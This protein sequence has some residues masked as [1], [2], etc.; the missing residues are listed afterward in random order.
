MQ[1]SLVAFVGSVEVLDEAKQA[2]TV[3]FAFTSLHVGMAFLGLAVIVLLPIER[4][5]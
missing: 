3:K 2:S 4:R 5:T 1:E